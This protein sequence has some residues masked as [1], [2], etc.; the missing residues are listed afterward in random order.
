MPRQK[1]TVTVDKQIVE[2]L[3]REVS[4]RRFRNRSHGFEY[5]LAKLKE[6]REE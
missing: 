3:D 5:A 1:V 6:K 2:W 4:K